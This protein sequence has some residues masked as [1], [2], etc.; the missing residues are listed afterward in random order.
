MTTEFQTTADTCNDFFELMEDT[1]SYFTEEY[2]ISAELAYVMTE[3]F[4]QTKISKLMEMKGA[5]N[6]E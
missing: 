4:A 1:V 2:G 3:A 6:N 5:L